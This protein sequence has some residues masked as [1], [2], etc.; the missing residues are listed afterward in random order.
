GHERRRLEQLLPGDMKQARLR[1]PGQEVADKFEAFNEYVAGDEGKSLEQLQGA[2]S[3]LNQYF[4]NLLTSDD[5]RRSAFAATLNPN[6]NAA[7]L[8]EVRLALSPVPDVIKGWF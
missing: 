6:Q 8:R 2:F 5:V 1:L 4:E 7:A 3:Q